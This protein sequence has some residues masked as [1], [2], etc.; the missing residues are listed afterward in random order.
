MGTGHSP[1]R[2]TGLLSAR[3]TSWLAASPGRVREG[4]CEHGEADITQHLEAWRADDDIADC[5]RDERARG[6]GGTELAK[7]KRFLELWLH[8]T[9]AP[10]SLVKVLIH[11][12]VTWP[13]TSAAA[14]SAMHSAR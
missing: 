2:C 12:P 7:A 8:P 13:R 3:E 5:H 14:L 10:V 6:N 9:C 11:S 4:A 1:R